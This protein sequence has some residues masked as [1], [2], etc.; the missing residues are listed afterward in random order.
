[1]KSKVV[2]KVSI[3]DH[4]QQ[5]F[6][7]TGSDACELIANRARCVNDMDPELMQDL[8]RYEDKSYAV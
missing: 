5:F 4:T 6:D 8:I 7:K 2:D 1:M 3:V